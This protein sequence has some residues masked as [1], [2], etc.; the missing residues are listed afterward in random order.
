MDEDNF[1]KT[2]PGT[3]FRLY[4]WTGRNWIAKEDCV[5]NKEG[6]I[7]WDLVKKE[8]EKNTLY[9]LVETKALDG[10][11]IKNKNNYFIWGKYEG[12]HL[13]SRVPKEEIRFFK[14][15]GRAHV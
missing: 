14:E 1:N 6:Y 15:I 4:K 2:L 3:K 7:G 10:Y 13:F 9:K 5:V 12:E 8:L 11:S